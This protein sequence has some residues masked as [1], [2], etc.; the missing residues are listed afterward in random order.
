[1]RENALPSCCAQ[2]GHDCHRPHVSGIAGEE[3]SFS[4]FGV[5]KEHEECKHQYIQLLENQA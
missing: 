3:P 2:V 1:M 5:R 4:K